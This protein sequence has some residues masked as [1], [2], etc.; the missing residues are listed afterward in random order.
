MRAALIGVFVVCAC[1]VA[2]TPAMAQDEARWFFEV[3]AIG[4]IPMD[5]DGDVLSF[6]N[7]S[8]TIDAESA[9]VPELS[10][11]FSIND[12]MD[13]A[14]AFAMANIDLNAKGP[15]GGWL[16][17][18]DTDFWMLQLIPRFRLAYIGDSAL[19]GGVIIA[20]SDYDNVDISPAAHRIRGV[21]SASFDSDVLAGAL[22]RFDTPIG[23]D[24]WYFASEVRYMMGGP[25][26][27][28]F[29]NRRP[30]AAGTMEFDP[31]VVGLT[32]GYQY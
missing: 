3:S 19:K 22:L 14:L 4:I 12:R 6:N 17:F 24:G 18:G 28:V 23:K 1:L 29:R 5:D 20:Y 32:L 7:G 31:L 11:G 15:R 2:A 16:E 26:L 21:T 8:T 13:L 25:E 9:I 27:Q 10:L 30:A